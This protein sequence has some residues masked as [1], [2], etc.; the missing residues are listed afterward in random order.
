MNI[1]SVP[2][3]YERKASQ[4]S[5]DV[6]RAVEVGD[7]LNLASHALRQILECISFQAATCA[8]YI[9]TLRLR[10]DLSSLPDE[11]LAAVLEHSAYTHDI[12][13]NEELAAIRT[14]KVATALSHTCQ[15][16]RRLGRSHSKVVESHL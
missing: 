2:F 13:G 14:V 15:R 5:E 1:T 4:T 9:K 10:K 6:T 12:F 3:L 11:V 8:N 16:F 7:V